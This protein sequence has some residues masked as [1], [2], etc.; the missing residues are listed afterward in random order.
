M[1]Q[2]YTT[3]RPENIDRLVALMREQGIETRIIHHAN[4]NRSAY[5]RFRYTPCKHPSC[6]ERDPWPQLWVCHA[7]DYTRARRLMRE[8]GV[9][10]D[11]RHAKE[12]AAEHTAST[13]A[14]RHHIITRIKHFLRMLII[15]VCTLT[16]MRQ[17]NLF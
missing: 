14:H 6:G 1:R 13:M 11:V 3:P 10:P 8:L 5:R 2:F 15:M 17:L 4:W 7:E 9:E 16:I 12:L